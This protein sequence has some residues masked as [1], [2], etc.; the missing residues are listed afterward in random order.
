MKKFIVTLSVCFFFL[1]AKAGWMP[2]E[3]NIR[4]FDYSM[5]TVEFDGN[6][7][8]QYS[9]S[10]TIA[11]ITPGNHYLKVFRYRSRP[12]ANGSNFPKLVFSGYIGIKPGK[13]IT[14]MINP[15][16]RF[17][18]LSQV[19]LLPP[20]HDPP[21]DPHYNGNGNNNYNNDDGYYDYCMSSYDFMELK[22]MVGNTTF[23]D[24]K[25]TLCKQAIAAN[26]MKSDQVYELMTLLT[27]ESNKLDL[28]KFAYSYVVDKNRY[29][30]VNGAFTFSSSIDE[31]N[32]YI[33]GE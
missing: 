23:D 10:H 33:N 12:Y 24:T 29:Y 7:Y 32:E 9:A 13:L 21:G 4:M 14:G 30:L 2:S 17:I 15:D 31:L 11:D 3:L 1:S 28:A 5:I 6:M 27:F 26:K 20:H 22:N 18:I 16:F 8:D 25:L 19:P